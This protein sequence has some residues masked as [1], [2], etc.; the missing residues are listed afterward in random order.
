MAKTTE[1]N[2]L[3]IAWNNAETCDNKKKNN[4]NKVYT[5]LQA[6]YQYNKSSAGKYF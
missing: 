4:N 3:Q 6:M 2:I 5:L 1:G